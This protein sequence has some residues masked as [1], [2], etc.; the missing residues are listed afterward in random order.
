MSKV[1]SPSSGLKT[2]P[3]RLARWF[4]ESVSSSRPLRFW[5]LPGASSS[6]AESRRRTRSAPRLPKGP[7]RPSALPERSS[8]C[9]SGA[10]KAV[11]LER[12][13]CE[14]SS[15]TRSSWHPLN[16]RE[17]NKFPLRL[18]FCSFGGKLP[19]SKLESSLSSR[20]NT[21]RSAIASNSPGLMFWRLPPWSSKR[22]NDGSRRGSSWGRGRFAAQSA[23]KSLRLKLLG[24]RFIRLL[25]EISKVCS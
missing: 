15:S 21:S 14:R 13:L 23:C 22:C 7:A 25:P 20:F 6:C 18:K 17:S 5:K 24:V 19:R 3:G 9:N 16:S 10:H 4:P 8:P 11:Q 12:R 2:S 1:F